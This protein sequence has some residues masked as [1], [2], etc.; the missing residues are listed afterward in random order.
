MQTRLSSSGAVAAVLWWLL[1][2]QPPRVKR[3]GERALLWKRTRPWHKV[4]CTVLYRGGGRGLRHPRHWRGQVEEE[5]AMSYQGSTIFQ[6]RQEC[7]VN[8]VRATCV[9]ANQEG[10]TARFPS[11][12][13]VTIQ[14]NATRR[15]LLEFLPRCVQVRSVYLTQQY[16]N[17][18]PGQHQ[19]G[20]PELVLGAELAFVHVRQPSSFVFG[21]PGRWNR[22]WFLLTKG[23]FTSRS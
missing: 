16:G 3:R 22:G 7:C 2:L 12:A 6:S 11:H 5:P 13:W 14:H 4:G 10:A 15:K 20:K 18:A 17:W 1:V 9:V 19:P 23:P 8:R 21:G